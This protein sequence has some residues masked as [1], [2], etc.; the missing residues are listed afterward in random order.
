MN[1]V[2]RREE[3][4]DLL[5]RR[6]VTREQSPGGDTEKAV[7]GVAKDPHVLEGGTSV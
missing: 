7:S 4:R 2:R 3:G 6:G 5:G 1:L